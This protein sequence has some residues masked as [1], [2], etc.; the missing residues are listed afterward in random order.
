M[1]TIHSD[2]LRLE[3]V[4]KPTAKIDLIDSFAL[5]F[6]VSEVGK[7]GMDLNLESDLPSLSL[8]ELRCILY[9]EQRR[10]NHFHKRYD[11]PVEA[12]LREIVQ[13]IRDSI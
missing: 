5:T 10:W 8:P 6:D 9:T 11:P 1:S 12:K 3:D 7:A 2:D 13:L 4:P